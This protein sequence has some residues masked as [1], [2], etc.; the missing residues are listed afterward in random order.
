V[1]LLGLALAIVPLFAGFVPV[2]ADGRRRGLHD[3]LAG[4]TVAYVDE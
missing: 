3:Y 4:T 1:R 2:L